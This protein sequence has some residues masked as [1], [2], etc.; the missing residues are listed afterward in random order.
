MTIARRLTLLLVVFSMVPILGLGFSGVLIFSNLRERVEQ[1]R[2]HAKAEARAH[3]MNSVALEAQLLGS[4]LRE[5]E[6]DVRMLSELIGEALGSACAAGCHGEVTEQGQ[7]FLAPLLRVSCEKRT[8]TQVWVSLSNGQRVGFPSV[9]APSSLG[10][11]SFEEFRALVAPHGDPSKQPRWLRPRLA[12]DSQ[13]WQVSCIF[14]LVLEQAVVGVVGMDTDVS[15]V[16]SEFSRTRDALGQ[17]FFVIDEAS[18]PLHVD[19]ALLPELMTAADQVAAWSNLATAREGEDQVLLAGRPLLASSQ[20]ALEVLLQDM[21]AGRSGMVTLPSPQPSLVTYAPIEAAG[22][23]LG[24]VTTPEQSLGISASARARLDRGFSLF[25]W[26]FGLFSVGTIVLTTMLGVVSGRRFSRP[27]ASMIA[28]IRTVSRG[29]S[30]TP[31][32]SK[33]GDELEVLAESANA[34]VMAQKEKEQL[35]SEIVDGVNEAIFLHDAVDGTVLR[36]NRHARTMFR[37]EEAA[38]LGEGVANMLPNGESFSWKSVL[39]KIAAASRGSLSPFEWQCIDAEGRM[40]WTEVNL[41]RAQIGGKPVILAVLRDI[42]ARKELEEQ[43]LALERNLLQTQKL[44]SLGVMAGGIAH[45][46]N[47]LLTAVLGHTELARLDLPADSPAVEC[48]GHVEQAARRAADLCRQMLAYSGRASLVVAPI[49]V[50][51]VLLELTQLLKA[52]I[53]KKAELKLELPPSV[54][55]FDGDATQIRQVVMNLLLNAADAIGEERGTI[56]VRV[57]ERDWSQSEL[58]GNVTRE[59]LAPGRYIALEITDT[60]VGMSPEVMNRI[61]EPFFTTKFTGRGLGLSAV[62]GIVKSHHGLLL[63]QSQ[64]G[65]GSSFTVAFPLTSR[66][67][68]ASSSVTSALPP[69]AVGKVLFVDDEE[70]LRKVGESMLRALNLSC[71]LAADGEEALRLFQAHRDTINLIMVDMTMPKMDGQQTLRA[72][73]ELDPNLKVVLMSGFAETEIRERFAECGVNGTLQ[74]P[75]DLATLGRVLGRA[76][77]ERQ[78][79]IVS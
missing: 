68:C 34:M 6:S 5:R 9:A 28:S 45:D 54:P 73:R 70:P 77:A 13:R 55:P 14:P 78:G 25:L 16:F 27:L 36:V 71:L 61:F 65:E 79:T 20:G 50:N 41:S 24:V 42:S 39:E 31:L 62:V 4:R 8:C 47:N 17:R 35:L 43:R 63:L 57:F 11:P 72:L 46:F 10:F 15:T 60:G 59:L 30:F 2:R 64:K 67:A 49:D 26:V 29:G 52:A 23:S 37:C 22:W 18:R 66:V 7:Q 40:F 69:R 21:T 3:L 12:P 38:L 1:N 58:S 33:T 53:S 51:A 56:T 32:E 75:F 74:K 44:E 19:S 76:L 48:L